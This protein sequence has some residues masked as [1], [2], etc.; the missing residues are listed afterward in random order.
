MA[1]TNKSKERGQLKEALSLVQIAISDYRTKLEAIT[2]TNEE[3]DP[4]LLE[5]ETEA[6]YYC[7]MMID[8]KP[9]AKILLHY[10]YPIF[11]ILDEDAP[12]AMWEELARLVGLRAVT[13]FDL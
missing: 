11:R 7:N 8:P 5:G 10:D 6:G 12:D 2:I 13:S 9:V 3:C 4:I 1:D